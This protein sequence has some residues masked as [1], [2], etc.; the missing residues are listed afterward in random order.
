MKKIYTIIFLV[1]VNFVTKAQWVTTS[2]PSEPYTV[3]LAANDIVV[4][5]GCSS[6]GSNQGGHRTLDEGTNWLTTGFS[7]LSKFNSLAI[8][9]STGTIYAGGLACFYQSFDNGANFTNTNSGLS[10]NTT[11]DILVDGNNLYA[12]V[13][14]VY[15]STNGGFNWSLISPAINS[16]KM[17][18][19]EN[20]ILVGTM[21]AGVYLSV[22][23]GSNWTNPTAGLPTNITDVKIIGTNLLVSTAS[24]IYIS[25]NNGTSWTLTNL[26]SPTE[27]IYQVGSMLFA[28]CIGGGG[29]YY[30]N[31]GGNTWI[32]SN[33]GLSNTSVYSLTSNSNYLFAGTAGYTFR[34]PLSDY[35]ILT[36]ITTEYITT[37]DVTIAPNPTTGIL[38][39]NQPTS[40]KSEIEIY[41]Q[42]G[43]LID[44]KI[45]TGKTSTI[46]LSNLKKGIY[47]VRI[48][49]LNKN[50]VS[51]KI[52]LQ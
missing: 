40:Q 8:N 49:D 41:N 4:M 39:I 19:I 34:R 21:T 36:S 45:T 24:G 31:D 44:T 48:T 50:V 51:K 3:A 20:T 14:G 33:T 12:S 13:F 30:S 52:V 6:A 47:L 5:A 11:R 26:S 29:V 43:K 42:L 15:L 18:K 35:G 38:T 23:N 16:T 28:G 32:A 25:T 1:T 22:D 9:P 27:C 46:D 37:K 2:G 10:S 17:D 7:L